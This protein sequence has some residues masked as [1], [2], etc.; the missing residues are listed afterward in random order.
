MSDPKHPLRTA[1]LLAEGAA[2]LD[3]ILANSH[4]LMVEAFYLASIPQWYDRRLLERMRNRDDGR[5]AGLITRLNR[6]SFVSAVRE[7]EGAEP[8]YFV[9]PNERS[10]LQKRWIAE[11]PQAYGAAH[12]RALAFWEANPDPNPFAQAQTRLYHQFFV[13]FDAGVSDLISLFRPV[14]YFDDG[15]DAGVGPDRPERFQMPFRLKRDR[16]AYSILIGPGT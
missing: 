14:L 6:Y 5:E 2:E 10:A 4:P 15:S 16:W 11:D 8:A 12:Q 3:V 7:R 9:R 13:D 1:D